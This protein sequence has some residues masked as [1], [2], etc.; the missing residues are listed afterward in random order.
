MRGAM[1]NS[2]HRTCPRRLQTAVVDIFLKKQ[3][4]CRA[5]ASKE[6]FYNILGKVWRCLFVVYHWG[7]SASKG[8]SSIRIYSKLYRPATR[9]LCRYCALLD[10]VIPSGHRCRAF[11]R[12]VALQNHRGSLGRGKQVLQQF[13]VRLLLSLRGMALNHP[14]SPPLP[15]L[16]PPPTPPPRLLRSQSALGFSE[17]DAYG[18]LLLLLRQGSFSRTSVKEI[19]CVGGPKLTTRLYH[20]V[21][22]GRPHE[23]LW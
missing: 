20:L 4:E 18:T 16:P 9:H 21:D 10:V 7:P 11:I 14:T 12:F 2:W 15:P 13:V 23:D 1:P 19:R 17:D 22:F 8:R 3:L 6:M 5:R